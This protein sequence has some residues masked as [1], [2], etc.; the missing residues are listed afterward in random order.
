[1][2]ARPTHYARFERARTVLAD[3]LGLE[4][5]PALRE[6]E[7]QIL[8]HDAD[9]GDRRGAAPPTNMPPEMSTFVGRDAFVDELVALM[10]D[11]R[12]V[13]IIGHGGVGKTRLAI[14]TALRL[15]DGLPGG[16]WLVELSSEHGERGVADAFMRTFGDRLGPSGSTSGA[17]WLAAG[18]GETE[19]LVVVDNCE[20]VLADAAAAIAALLRS[21]PLAR[22]LATSREPL[23]VPGE[24]VRRL[25]PLDPADA[26]RLFT[27]R[28]A[29]S[30]SSFAVE[31]GDD[32]VIDAIC[33][34]VDRLPLAIE[35]AAARTR[36]FTL[37]QLES[38]LRERLSVVGAMGGARPE[39]QQ[40]LHAA[41]AWSFDLLTADERL[42]FARLSVFSGGCT[43]DA[44]TRVCSSADLPA[45]M[46]PLLLARLVD[47]SLL[48]VHPG[49]G[50]QRYRFLRS[51]AEHARQRLDDMGETATFRQRHTDWLVDLT[52]DLTSELRRP[53]AVEAA[54]RLNLELPNLIRAARWGVG[55]GDP[56][57][58][59]RLGVQL[60][61]YAFVSANVQNDEQ[62]LLELLEQATDAPSELTCRARM[63]AGLLSIGRT[64]RRTWAMDAVDVARTASGVTATQRAVYD[65][66]GVSLS[67]D[68]IAFARGSGDR[69][70]LLETLTI[71]SLHLAAIGSHPD[72]LRALNTEAAQLAHE[73]SDEWSR[74]FVVGLD[75]LAA[76]VA[77]E[78]ESAMVL[79]RRAVGDLQAQGDIGTAALLLVSLS[80]TAELLGDIA[81]ATEAMMTALT[82]G[83]AAGFRSAIILRA[84]ACWLQGRNGE[85]DTAL[86]LGRE[87]VELA[88]RPFNPV[89][90]AQ[91][92]FAFGVAETLS[93]RHQAAEVHLR[94]ALDAHVG[95]SMVRETAMDLR[96][97]ADLRLLQ[98]AIDE[99]IEHHR[100]AVLLALE[101]GLP[102]TVMLTARS[103]ACSLV[104]REPEVAAQLVGF[105]D[106]TSAVFHYHQTPD[107]L[108]QSEFVIGRAI[109][110]RGA[111]AVARA[112]TDGS[113][114]AMDE[115]SEL[116]G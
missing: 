111:P 115:L 108:A 88:R 109:D 21:C 103:L 13:T 50:G 23:G 7:L 71:G 20:H 94:E 100:R 114:M 79:L 3:E 104:E 36:T 81:G 29:D 57:V 68:A 116:L 70:L 101:V 113:L 26:V 27:T 17:D 73:L 52:A 18:L 112:R 8:D 56:V 96:H 77:G 97:L 11:R 43:L 25:E 22:V 10:A 32:E 106:A 98:G 24:L 89:V 110:A 44:A 53:G 30:N 83:S 66:D 107:E 99:A 15:N 2:D 72:T 61:W 67:V 93:G 47:R 92:L 59:L 49:V 46:V 33:A 105:A 87:V 19:L 42:L 55:D 31:D 90:R 39:R 4:P 5:G 95:M 51:V 82:I 86:E 41:V 58:A 80:E 91:A 85:V 54:G 28:A 62:L 34:Q 102:W 65:V 64:R 37:T 74:A 78:L 69:R 16:T 75:G 6:L 84:V 38:L 14:E 76:Y 1:M 48:A 40:T 45:D 60:G 35:L 9:L 63:W 12:L